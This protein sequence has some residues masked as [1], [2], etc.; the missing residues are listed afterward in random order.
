[1]D[2]INRYSVWCQFKSQGPGCCLNSTLGGGVAHKG[3]MPGDTNTRTDIV[4]QT[5][6]LTF[7]NWQ[8][9]P[10]QVQVTEIIHLELLAYAVWC[11][12]FKRL[13]NYQAGIIDEN[14]NPAPGLENL[15]DSI[16]YLV[17]IT[18]AASNGEKKLW[19]FLDKLEYSVDMDVDGCHP[20]TVSDQRREHMVANPI[21]RPG[22][23]YYLFMMD[24]ITHYY[25]SLC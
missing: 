12:F 14:I 8:D 15:L 23:D 22:E 9:S 19:I 10:D 16:V 3:G 17:F 11:A 1:M 7:H 20:V 25:C 2:Q 18:D 24:C 13:V 21:F 5:A 6:A 4:D